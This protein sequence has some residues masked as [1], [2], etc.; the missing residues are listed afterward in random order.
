M[1]LGRIAAAHGIRGWLR[2]AS[3]T[4]PPDALLEYP[5]WLLRRPDGTESPCEVLEASFDGS[6]LRVALAGIADRT[7]AEQL[8]GCEIAV[9]RSDLPPAND[10]EYYQQDLLGFEVRNLEGALL[11]TLS[12]F[13]GG[14]AQPLMAVRGEREVW[15][16]AVPA[17]LKRVDL[18]ARQVLVDWPSDW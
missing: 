2:V 1:V 9:L 12:Y 7:A 17:H 10:R 6:N 15:V 5:H 16:P 13:V 11:G 3:Y 18:A 8:R 4:E 14:T